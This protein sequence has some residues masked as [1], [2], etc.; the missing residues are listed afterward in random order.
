MNINIDSNSNSTSCTIA[1]A[2]HTNRVANNCLIAMARGS[3]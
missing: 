3:L 2:N 1:P